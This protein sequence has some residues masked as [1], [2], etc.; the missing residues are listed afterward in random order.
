M[1]EVVKETPVLGIIT[2]KNLRISD[3]NLFLDQRRIDASCCFSVLQH[4][5]LVQA[6]FL[7]RVPSW[8]ELTFSR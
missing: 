3:R 7:V 5:L 2:A 6:L 1:V 4:A 8:D